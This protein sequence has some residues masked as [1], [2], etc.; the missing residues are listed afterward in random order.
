MLFI[1]GKV[2]AYFTFHRLAYKGLKDGKSTT[3]TAFDLGYESL[4]GFRCTYK[5]LF[6]QLP[7]KSISKDHFRII[8]IECE[9][10]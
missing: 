7:T 6:G 2:V 3:V 9:K 8:S 4:S 5:K 10:F 1:V